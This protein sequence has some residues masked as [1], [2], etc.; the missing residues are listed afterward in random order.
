D[1]FFCSISAPLRG[2]LEQANDN[3][4]V[5]I[6]KNRRCGR[7]VLY[8]QSTVNFPSW[9]SNLIPAASG[10]HR[11]NTI[12]LCRENQKRKLAC[13]QSP[14]RGNKN[15]IIFVCNRRPFWEAGI[16]PLNYSRA[17]TVQLFS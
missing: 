6:A 3:R 2:A 11:L 14:E 7:Y 12:H 9:T 15:A 8:F 13:S 10:E 16:L 1:S 17:L 5:S 4:R